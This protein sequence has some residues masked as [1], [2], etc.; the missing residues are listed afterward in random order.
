MFKKE[1]DKGNSKWYICTLDSVEYPI[2]EWF[3]VNEGRA[4]RVSLDDGP[5]NPY[6]FFK[7]G[8]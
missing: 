4:H 2:Q 8:C 1:V 6:F 3:R 7:R 5:L